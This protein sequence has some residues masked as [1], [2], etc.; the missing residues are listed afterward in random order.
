M[1]VMRPLQY[2]TILILL[3]T[4]EGCN[5]SKLS[6]AKSM[7]DA[8]CPPGSWVKALNKCYIFLDYEQ[9]TN[10]SVTGDPGSFIYNEKVCR[11]EYNGTLAMPVS[12][13]AQATM[14]AMFY[15]EYPDKMSWAWLGVRP[16]PANPPQMY[17]MDGRRVLAT[18]WFDSDHQKEPDFE[19]E[20]YERTRSGGVESVRYC[21]GIGTASTNRGKWFAIDCALH[22]AAICERNVLSFELNVIQVKPKDAVSSNEKDSSFTVSPFIVIAASLMVLTVA[23]LCFTLYCTKKDVP[24]VKAWFRRRG[25]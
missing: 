21:V 20:R 18:S 12:A 10:L 14:M 22:G 15:H 16:M 13:N 24:V 17:W 6:N 3:L 25:Q 8:H 5:A 9:L 1:T 2:G 19:V 4:Y 23:L 7:S 11:V